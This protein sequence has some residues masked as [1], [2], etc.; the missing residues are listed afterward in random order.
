MGAAKSHNLP[1]ASCRTGKTTGIIQYKSE[2]LKSEN[3]EVDVQ[4][5]E[6]WMP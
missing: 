5:Q 4:V 1:S 2:G 6:K 3:G